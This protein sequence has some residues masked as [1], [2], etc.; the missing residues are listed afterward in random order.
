[1]DSSSQFPVEFVRS[2]PKAELHVHLE[3]SVDASTL[4]ALAE[5]HDVEPPAPDVAGVE[6][7]FDFDGFEGIVGTFVIILD[8]QEGQDQ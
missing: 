3:G 6:A 2:L 5:R 4:L 1:M 7:W 8:R